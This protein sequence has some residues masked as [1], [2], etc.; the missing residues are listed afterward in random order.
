MRSTEMETDLRKSFVFVH[1]LLHFGD[2][3]ANT[4]SRERERE[5]SHEQLMG[6]RSADSLYI[7]IH[8]FNMFVGLDIKECWPKNEK[9]QNEK[10]KE[11]LFAILPFYPYLKSHL[12]WF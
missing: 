1:F 9:A 7:G 2:R 6:G 10:K 3:V 12:S 11:T 5:L 8:G 4:E